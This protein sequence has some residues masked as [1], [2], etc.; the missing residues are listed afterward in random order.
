MPEME[1]EPVEEA[2]PAAPP[3]APAPATSVTP[4]VAGSFH[5]TVALRVAL[6]SALLTFMATMLMGMLGLF[7]VAQFFLQI[8][9]TAA[10]GFY[11]VYLY[12]RRT[13]LYLNSRGGARVGWLTG[14]FGFV[15]NVVMLTMGM[16]A[17]M[18]QGGLAAMFDPAKNG[19]Q[20]PPE[21]AEKVRELASD[22]QTM[23]V[24]LLFA[25]VFL[26][27]T[28]TLAASLGGMLGAKV[29]EKE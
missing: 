25:L 2:A 5:D 21:V 17:M 15:I 1:P 20:A 7:T 18:S 23:I 24:L 3:A 12:R 4:V 8:I 27:M 16:V 28:A 9:M 29:M 13:G 11:A 19:I 14:V 6:I 26:F 10:G 22:P